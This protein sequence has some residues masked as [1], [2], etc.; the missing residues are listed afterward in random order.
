MN[1]IAAGLG[2]VLALSSTG[3]VTRLGD[4]TI[5]STKNIELSQMGSFERAPT[6]VEGRDAAHIIIFIPTGT[7]DL[8]EAVDRAIE[9]VP[10]GVALVDAVCY[11]SWWY[12]PYVYG[13]VQ[14]KVE[15]NVLV[16][17][18]QRGAR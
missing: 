16:D 11:S 5:L 7:P 6:R 3:C 18:R 14:Y 12:I 4:M 17:P 9:S 2:L 10:G 1:R 8:E 15:G 13:Q